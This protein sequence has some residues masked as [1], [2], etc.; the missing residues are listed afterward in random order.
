MKKIFLLFGSNGNL[1]KNAVK[2][3]LEKNYDQYYFFA[4]NNFEIDS[5]KTNY[6]IIKTLDLA[7]EKNIESAFSAVSKQ[8]ENTYFLYSTIGGFYG[9]K[10]VEDTDYNQWKKMLEINLNTA[11]LISKYFMKLVRGTQGG[12][13]CFTS[14]Y[15]SFYPEPGKTAYNLSK[16]GLNYL[17]ESLA[18]EGSDL[19]I[20]ANAVAPF[21]IDTASNR[22]WITDVSKLISPLIICDAVES[23]FTDYKKVNGNIIRLT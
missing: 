22:E 18:L 3:F 16:S 2:Y 7:E 15:S 6:Q 8:I 5:K 11:F 1:G 9:G 20:S 10:S 19:G 21:A 14:A 23:L 12:S 13:I 17:V 4:R